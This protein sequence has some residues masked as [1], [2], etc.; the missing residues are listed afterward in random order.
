[1][2]LLVVDNQFLS[3]AQALVNQAKKEICLSSFKLEICDKPR[4]RALKEFF[5]S[6]VE[7]QKSG[8][9]V[10]VLFN[11]H[12][13]RRSVAKT[14]Y[15]ASLFLKQ[16]GID[17]RY[18]RNNRCCHAKLLIVDKEKI[19]LGSHNL[20]VRST[21]NNFEMSYVIPDPE[22]AA[23]VGGVFERIFADAKPI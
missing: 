20:S 17:I 19:L 5:D 10:K 3:V 2:G 21:Q 4:G 11:W 23:Q 13:D 15:S 8:V 14:N 1:M 16:S 9:K 22:T 18:L 12:D 6:I 7:K